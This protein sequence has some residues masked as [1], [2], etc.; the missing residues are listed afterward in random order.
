MA[1]GLELF[2]DVPIEVVLQKLGRVLH[3]HEAMVARAKRAI[4]CWSMAA[5]RCGVVKDMRVMIAKKAWAEPWQWGEKQQ[6]PA[7]AKR[8]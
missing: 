2:D 8:R 4:E 3:L 5:R 1:F 6:Q 7:K